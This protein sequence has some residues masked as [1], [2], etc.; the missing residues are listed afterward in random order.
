[1]KRLFFALWPEQHIRQQCE[2]LTDKLNGYG[3]PVNP[4]NLHVTLLFLGRI[5]PEQQA[6][7]T[8]EASQ[9]PVSPITLTFDCLSFWKKPAVLCL[10]ASQ[11]DQN[12]SKLNEILATIAK[13]QGIT[14]DDRPFTPHVTLLKKADSVIDIDFAPVLWRSDGFC[15]VESRSIAN[16][17]E[18]RII[19]R[20]PAN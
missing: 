18:Y 8:K 20:W 12:V 7:L 9:I 15:L 19:E 10:T 17:I 4:A 16:N 13:Q 11:F 6:V 2:I 3:K 5:S 14:V 1:M